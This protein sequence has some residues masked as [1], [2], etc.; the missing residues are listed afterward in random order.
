[1]AIAYVDSSSNGFN[2]ASAP[3]SVSHTLGASATRLIAA[4]QA[5]GGSDFSATWNGVAMTAVGS[6]NQ[7][8]YTTYVFELANPATGSYSVEFSWSGSINGRM[9]CAS[10]S[11][12]DTSLPL[13]S[14]SSNSSASSA[15]LTTN[16]T[17]I[18]GWTVLIAATYIAASPDITAGSGS[19]LRLVGTDV[20]ANGQRIGVF[21]SNANVA[22]ST[23]MAFDSTAASLN[24]GF[25]LSIPQINGATY[26]IG[27]DDCETTD[28][29]TGQV[30]SSVSDT[31]VTTDSAASG[32]GFSEKHSTTWTN[33][34]KS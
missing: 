25:V 12:D 34:N 6:K 16:H 33:Q 28:S 21:D 24:I 17:A 9:I 23:S 7:G 2:G 5:N 8:S 20:S 30:G 31:I 27:T 22:G 32:F 29:N 1:M 13:T 3:R 10:Y 11:G 19:T 4:I 15:S 18:T 14:F 26:G